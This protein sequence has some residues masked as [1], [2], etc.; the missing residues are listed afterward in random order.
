MRL[1][2]ERAMSAEP[3][4]T[5]RNGRISG[6]CPALCEQRRTFVL[7]ILFG[8]RARWLCAFCAISRRRR[9]LCL[10]AAGVLTAAWGLGLLLFLFAGGHGSLTV[11][12]PSLTPHP[13]G[14]HN[15]V[16]YQYGVVLRSSSYF[17]DRYAQHHPA[18]LVD[19]RAHPSLVEKWASEPSD[20]RPWV[21]LLW[22]GQH[23]IQ[24]VRIQHAGFVESAEF[25]V[26][27][28]L[29]TCLSPQA[30][31]P[32]VVINNKASVT[33]HDLR[34]LVAHGLRIDFTPNAP[35][36]LVRIFEIEV[37]GQ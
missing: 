13:P 29:V 22:N 37:W 33:E 28:Y 17:R 9:L 6:D 27:Q 4:A 10:G 12:L 35:G 24:R 36:A 5:I 2:D 21:E 1:L 16:A 7:G 34:C 23:A 15:L 8:L 32:L 25:T 14:E 19:G 11:S 31:R 18:F 26:Q 3:G 20:K 30:P